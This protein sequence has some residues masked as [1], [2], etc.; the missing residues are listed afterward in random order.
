MM[1]QTAPQKRYGLFSLA[2]FLLLLGG[3][4]FFVGFGSFV[5]RTLGALACIASVYLVRISNVRDRPYSVI[6]SGQIAGL[7]RRPGRLTWS[8]GVLSVLLAGASFLYLYNDARHGYHEVLP[9]YVFAGTALACAL[10]WSY[11]VSTFFQ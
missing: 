7:T 1:S 4:F 9:V 2:I 6:G 8:I 3:A 11:L 5:I 10:V